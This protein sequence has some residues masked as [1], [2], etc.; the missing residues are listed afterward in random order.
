MQVLSIL[1]KP[2]HPYVNLIGF[3][4]FLSYVA[5]MDGNGVVMLGKVVNVTPQPTPAQDKAVQTDPNEAGT[6]F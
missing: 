4:V 6:N 3:R 5:F 1:A 2:T